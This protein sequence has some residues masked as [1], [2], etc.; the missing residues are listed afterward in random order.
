MGFLGIL[1]S[2][3]YDYNQNF[4]SSI[5]RSMDQYL[6][7]CA[8]KYGV[9]ISNQ[10]LRNNHVELEKIFED[11]VRDK[12]IQ[13]ENIYDSPRTTS[14]GEYEREVATSSASYTILTRYRDKILSDDSPGIDL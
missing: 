4:I 12:L 11:I 8:R 1:V 14:Y 7:K 10:K 13:C 6:Y 2:K 9:D 3:T 5:I